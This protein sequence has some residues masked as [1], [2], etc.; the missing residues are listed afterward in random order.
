MVP[1]IQFA[2]ENSGNLKIVPLLR[3]TIRGDNQT[4]SIK[5]TKD[6]GRVREGEHRI[7]REEVTDTRIQVRGVRE[8]KCTYTTKEWRQDERQRHGSIHTRQE[9]DQMEDD[10][11][12]GGE[13]KQ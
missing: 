4:D 11:N 2:Q 10:A 12:A 7:C 5:T 3:G 1:L 8:N 9:G 13:G 6:K